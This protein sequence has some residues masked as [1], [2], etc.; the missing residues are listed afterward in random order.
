MVDRTEH[1]RASASLRETVP[2]PAT[3]PSACVESKMHPLYLHAV[4]LLAPLRL[5]VSSSRFHGSQCAG[6]EAASPSGAAISKSPRKNVLVG[7]LARLPM[8]IKWPW[9]T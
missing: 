2:A 9:R 6:A 8:P 4:E 1:L 7:L 3:S 5:C